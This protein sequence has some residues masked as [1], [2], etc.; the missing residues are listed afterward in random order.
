MLGFLVQ[1]LGGFGIEVQH[2]RVRGCQVYA[3][4]PLGFIS[5]GF[6]KLGR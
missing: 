2:L 6:L 1:G 3:A 5:W 4:L